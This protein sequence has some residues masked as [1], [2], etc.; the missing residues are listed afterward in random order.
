MISRR[1]FILGTGVAAFAPLASPLLSNDFVT[2]AVLVDPD[3]VDM[4]K[5][6]YPFASTAR[7]KLAGWDDF[8]DSGK[9]ES[10]PCLWVLVSSNWKIV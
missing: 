8:L 3:S 5:Q 9:S 2:S 1:T 7:L 4:I 6:K 10:E